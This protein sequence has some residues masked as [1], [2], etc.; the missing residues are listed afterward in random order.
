VTFIFLV[1]WTA[2]KALF[3]LQLVY[4]AVLPSKTYMVELLLGYRDTSRLFGLKPI[5]ESLKQLVGVIVAS[6]LF[7]VFSGW[8]NQLKGSH[9]SLSK[10]PTQLGRIGQFLV[11]NYLLFL[12]L[13]LCIYLF[14]FSTKVKEAAANEQERIAMLIRNAGPGLRASL[15]RHINL[16]GEQS[17]WRNRYFTALY[18]AVLAAYIISAIVLR[19]DGAAKFVGSVWDIVLKQILGQ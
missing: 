19:S 2:L 12:A 3:F 5:L 6:A 17:V 13:M 9:R 15:E 8:A 10:D 16:V 11:T 14:F 4:R 18:I 7:L 1:V